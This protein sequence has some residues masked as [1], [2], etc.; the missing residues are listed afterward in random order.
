MP[1]V[2]EEHAVVFEN[3]FCR[4]IDSNIKERGTLNVNANGIV[5]GLL[6]ED[7]LP[8]NQ[9]NQTHLCPAVP[10]PC[11]AMTPTETPSEQDAENK[12]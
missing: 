6:V 12:S 8:M 7:Q 1:V 3:N 5:N 9:T 10:F 2:S 4:T 11:E